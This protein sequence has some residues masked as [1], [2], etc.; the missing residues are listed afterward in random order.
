MGEYSSNESQCPLK[1]RCLEEVNIQ[2]RE[3]D[4]WEDESGKTES[5]MPS[6][7]RVRSRWTMVL[8]PVVSARG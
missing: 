6:G 5:P 3:A 4:K 8:S 1:G 7:E 2:K